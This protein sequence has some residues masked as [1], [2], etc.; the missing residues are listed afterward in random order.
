M[1][2]A[3]RKTHHWQGDKN[4][5]N[6]IL[7]TFN[8]IA[9]V[10]PGIWQ[11]APHTSPL[12]AR[13]GASPVRALEKSSR[14]ISRVH[15]IVNIFLEKYRWDLPY[16]GLL[17][18]EHISALKGITVYALTWI[19]S[20]TQL[21]RKITNLISNEHPGIEIQHQCYHLYNSLFRRTWWKQQSPNPQTPCVGAHGCPL[22]SPQTGQVRQKTSGNDV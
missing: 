8:Y 5:L 19:S 15:C 22:A 13:H 9:V 3:M 11:K 17:K 10:H 16:A 14:E 20:K 18:I 7:Y 21:H 6:Q 1:G 2:S 12:W 4:A